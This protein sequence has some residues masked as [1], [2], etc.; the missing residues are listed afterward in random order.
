MSKSTPDLA[1]A[2][3]PPHYRHNRIGGKECIEITHLMGFSA[4]C[5]VKYL[6]RAGHKAGQ[7]AEQ[8][9]RKA[10][11]YLEFLI[12]KHQPAWAYAHVPQVY[13]DWKLDAQREGGHELLLETLDLMSFGLFRQAHAELSD[14]I[15]ENYHNG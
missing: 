1:Q 7:P 10:L 13:R 4:A 8:D 2:I 5:V 9:L 15:K 12:E 3:N 6:W 14:Y 11:R